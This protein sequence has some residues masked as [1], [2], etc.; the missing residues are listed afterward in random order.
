MPLVVCEKRLSVLESNRHCLVMG[1]PG[2]GKT[3][4]A[5]MKAQ[6]RI[7]DGLKEG[8]NVLFLSF[9]RAAVARITD[10]A[11]GQISSKQQKTLAIQTFHSFFWQILRGYAYLLGAPR[12]LSLVLAHDEKAMRDGIER[13]SPSWGEWECKRSE[14]FQNQGRVC[15][16]LFAPL[17][18]TLLRK[19]RVIRNRVAGRYPLILVDEAQ[20][21]GNEQWECVKLLGQ[22]AQIICL[23]DP[24]QMIYDFLPGVG[25]ERIGHIREAL[26]PHEIDLGSEN[27]RSPGTEIAVFARDILNGRAQQSRGYQGV[28]RLQFRSSAAE[29]DGAI[30]S[31]IGVLVKRIK[32]QT[33]CAP[34]SIA[35]IATYGSGVAIISSAL[36][37]DKPIRHQVL[38]DEA[39]ALLAGRVAAFLLEPRASAHHAADVA[40][41]LELASDAFRAKGNK[42]ALE[43]SRKCFGYAA[44]YRLGNIPPYRV[45]TAAESLV[46]SA[47]SRRLSGNPRRDWTTVKEDLRDLGENIFREIAT[48]LDYMVAFARGKRIAENLSEL[49]LQ[50]GV[51]RGAREAL[52]D[53][54]A[55]DQLLSGNE[56]LKGI[57]VMN[58]HKCKGKQFD[59]VIL[60]RQQHHSPF[61][62]RN[63][64]SPF[65]A[66]RRLLHMAVTRAK[67]HVLVLDDVFS[68][69]PIFDKFVL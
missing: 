23:A 40:T 66:S 33:G 58:M 39:F 45:I 22:T 46:R 21:T 14:L 47:S 62:W 65:Y 12:S 5:L 6:K 60:Y 27:Q 1:G 11:A 61:I 50:H 59:G 43:Q 17:T 37:H 10:A 42:T 36:Q 48:Q 19:S 63:E 67:T 69:C 38:F 35:I 51:Y 9:S 53:A 25:P 28:S 26:K 18:A 49:W 56:E 68:A 55:Q 24:D 54:L 31:S 32:D 16:D 64:P 29:R 13:E 34:K 7:A 15:F 52:D 20:D 57:H 41:L 4:L 2:C 8:Q 3:T 30:R 44:R